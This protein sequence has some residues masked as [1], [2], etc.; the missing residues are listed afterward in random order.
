[1]MTAHTPPPT[2]RPMGVL[3]QAS[4][5]IGGRLVPAQIRAAAFQGGILETDANVTKGSFVPLRLLSETPTT[6]NIHVLEASDGKMI[7][8]LYGTD[9]A[10]R[11]A[12]EK[13]VTDL[14]DSQS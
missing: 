10:A 11:K 5:V 7:F 6:V 3:P 13:I 14:R 2:R 9:G 1:M 8:R 4:V 12:W